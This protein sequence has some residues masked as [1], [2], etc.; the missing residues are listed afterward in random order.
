MLTECIV[1]QAKSLLT[2]MVCVEHTI[3][4]VRSKTMTTKEQ[5]LSILLQKIEEIKFSY[6]KHQL[7]HITMDI[8]IELY[9][10]FKWKLKDD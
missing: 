7:D 4:K 8:L 9:E 3:Q 1:K 2:I 5:V 6:H 10:E